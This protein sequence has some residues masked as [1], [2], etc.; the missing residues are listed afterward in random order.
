MACSDI[1]A[2]HFAL[3]AETMRLPMS[4]WMSEAHNRCV[5]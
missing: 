2:G 3:K 1:R 5:R 4:E